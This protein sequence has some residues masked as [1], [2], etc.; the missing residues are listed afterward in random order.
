MYVKNKFLNKI[1]KIAIVLIVLECAYLYALPPI[2]NNFVPN[3]V[4]EN[5]IE[6]N[7]NANIEY[8]NL[9][10]K[11][12]IKPDL[13]IFLKEINVSDKNLSYSFLNAD[14]LKIKVSLFDFLNK[15]INIKSITA[16]TLNLYAFQDKNGMTNIE[17]LFPKNGESKFK[18][19][20]KNN[21]IKIQNYYLTFEDKMLKKSLD[22]AGNLDELAIKNNEK[23]FIKTTGY[24]VTKNIKSDFDIDLKS[25]FPLS[26]QINKDIISG[27]CFISNINLDVLLP[28]MAKFVDKNTENISGD[29]KYFQISTIND[30]GKNQVSI[31]TLLKNIIYDRKDWLNDA[32]IEGECKINAHIE[33]EKNQIN[34]KTIS[35]TANKIDIKA[36]GSINFKD[37]TPEL[38]ITT[39]IKNSRAEKIFAMLPENITKKLGTIKKVKVYKVYGDVEAKADIK[40]KIPQPDIIGYIKGRNIKALDKSIHKLHN[41]TVDITFDKRKLNMDILIDLFNNQ[42]ATVKGYTYFYRD[43][44]NNVNIKTTNNLDFPLTQKIAVPVSKVFNFTLG[45]IVEMDITSGKGILDLNVQGNINFVNVNGF[46]E[47]RDAA[48]TYNGLHGE[49][50]DGAG[51]VD[52]KGDVISFKSKQAYVKSNLLD[53]DGY[54]KIN[55]HL[56]FN[57]RSNNALAEDILEIINNSFLLKDVKAGLAV[58]TSAEKPVNLNTNIKAK[59]VPVPYGHP[60][61]P[62]DEAFEDMRV[63]GSVELI[64]NTCHIEGFKTPF[65]HING[66]VD[67][68]E[69]AV[70]IHPVTAIS[71]TSPLTISGKVTNDV[72]TKIPDVDITVTSDNVN[73]KDTIKFLTE[74][75]LYPEEYIDLS[76]LYNIDSKHDLYFK[77]KAKSID[78]AT[79]KAYAVM[80]FIPDENRYGL[81]ATS[82]KVIMDKAVVTVD[83]VIADL[84]GSK[85]HLN[86]NVTHIDTI[87]PLYNLDIKTENLN[88]ENFND[89]SKTIIIPKVVSNILNDFSNYQGLADLNLFLRKNILSGNINLKSPQLTHKKTNIPLAFDDFKVIFENNKV[90]M[91]DVCANIGDM[92]FYGSFIISDYYK[93]PD[94]DGYFTSKLT[95]NFID[96]YLQSG[97]INKLQLYG[98][99]SFSSTISGTIDNLKLEPKLTLQKNADISYDG[100][101]LGEKNEKRELYGLVELIDKNI[102]IENFEYIK[103]ISSQNNKTYPIKF[104]DI[105]GFMKQKEKQIIPK[106]INLKTHKNMPARFLNIMLKSSILKQGSFSGDLKININ[107]KTGNPQFIGDLD[108]RNINIPLFDTVI[109]H[110]SVNSNN[111]DIN[112]SAFG[113][114]IDERVS[115]KTKIKNDLSCKP[116]IKSLDIYAEKIDKDKLFEILTTAHSA[117][118]DNNQIKNVDLSGLSISN[119]H[120]EIKELIVKGLIAEKFNADFSIN[121]EG[122]FSAKNITLNIGQGTMNGEMEYNLNNTEFI[123]NFGLAN[124]DSNYIAE[125]LFEGKNQVYGNANGRIYVS[126]KGKTEEDRIKNLFGYVYFDMTDGKL[127]KLGSLEYLLRASNILKSGITGFT[128]NSI[129]ELLNLVKT[130]YYSNINGYCLIENGIAQN[131]EIFSTGENLSLYIHGSYDISKTHAQMEILGKLSKRI[132]TIF[133][134]VGNISLNTFFNLIPGVSLFDFGRKN[135]I[136]DVEKIPSFT[137]GEYDARIFQAIVDGDINDSGFVQSFKWVK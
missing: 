74:S 89:T 20:I 30:N 32:R 112:I 105:T 14:N 131:I 67:F 10:F 24:T 110:I 17:N 31:N 132:S 117:M 121:E 71:G 128:I 18:P 96:N 133:G 135:F 75:Y 91:K 49:I 33:P 116:Q 108:F 120:L 98:D 83:N 101:N 40:G 54:V 59:I 52:F 5:F 84:Y 104:I 25:T 46:C 119:G 53:I 42:K 64:D 100:I 50:K 94:I 2:L 44:I 81:V 65:E 23:I 137:N 34:V 79:D 127:P 126:T 136:E 82:G 69:T 99:I 70:D 48:L 51:R 103:Y 80:N 11:T 15:K 92:P 111:E 56:D 107:E 95:Q 106:E 73:L 63:K 13:T 36:L 16:Q 68:T 76:S 130:G 113:F 55:N 85:L 41:G 6:K 39:E 58:F 1:F 97:I 21:S 77:Y 102:H 29:I 35:L 60:P 114:L 125:T 4:I 66:I 122:L 61:L 12:H 22:I 9:K 115:I 78:F 7:T 43:G 45:P 26:K 38:N 90:K 8:S 27:N 57:I 47:F 37:K 123:G 72:K 87:N 19:L 3:D 118:R 124:V 86:G 88:L 134:K 109:K 129:L 62:P 93:L 28:F